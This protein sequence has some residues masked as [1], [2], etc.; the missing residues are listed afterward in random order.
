MKFYENIVGFYDDMTRFSYRIEK[1]KPVFQNLVKKHNIKTAL[2]VACGTGL[3]TILLNELGVSATG[4]DNSPEML[5][6]AETNARKRGLDLTFINLAMQELDGNINEKFDAVFC[7]GNSLPHLRDTVALNDAVS[8]FSGMLHKGGTV[9]LQILNYDKILATQ[10]R[11][12][13]IN[14]SNNYEFI[15]F[16]DFLDHKI[17][18]NLLVIKKENDKVEHSLNSTELVPYL[19][20]DITRILQ[21]NNFNNIQTF[22][23]LRGNPFRQHTSDNLVI[24]AIKS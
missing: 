19:R 5:N 16:Y 23:D 24:T 20:D 13:N 8:Q 11:I 7:L 17:R 15:R 1:E 14:Y 6:R 2:D 12:V 18:F 9:F 22:A 4:V 10:N 3:H 21:N